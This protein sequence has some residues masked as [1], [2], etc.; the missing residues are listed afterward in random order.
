[1]RKSGKLFWDF[2]PNLIVGLV[3]TLSFVDFAHAYEVILGGFSC[4]FPTGT[5]P[6]VVY[7]PGING[8]YYYKCSSTFAVSNCF[9]AP[10]AKIYYA[11]KSGNGTQISPYILTGCSFKASLCDTTSRYDSSTNS[12]VSCTGNQQPGEG[13]LAVPAGAEGE[14]QYHTNTSCA[15]CDYNYYLGQY[16]PAP[17]VTILKC[18]QCPD[19]GTSAGT[20]DITSCRKPAG[21][22]GSDS[23]GSFTCGSEGVYSK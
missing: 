18:T 15:Y 21:W 13:S 14:D 2:M 11:S 23:T 3:A 7:A 12:C 20:G 19:G 4:G 6:G 9:G 16:S 5:F 17:G 8:Y 1:M 22:T 10:A